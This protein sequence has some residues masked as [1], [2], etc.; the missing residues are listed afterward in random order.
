MVLLKLLDK[1]LL[2]LTVLVLYKL[3]T[4]ALPPVNVDA[5]IPNRLLDAEPFKCKFGRESVSDTNTLIVSFSP[6]RKISSRSF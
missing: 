4:V 6:Y 5:V 1:R 3:A 2:L